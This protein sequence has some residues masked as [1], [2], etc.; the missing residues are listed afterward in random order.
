MSTSIRKYINLIEGYAWESNEYPKFLFEES[1]RY[2]V[3]SLCV[4]LNLRPIPMNSKLYEILFT[5][6]NRRIAFD[7]EWESK[8]MHEPWVA[9]SK[10]T[11]VHKQHSD[12]LQ[13]YKGPRKV[14]SSDNNLNELQNTD[15]QRT[16]DIIGKISTDPKLQQDLEPETDR[17]Y[18][19]IDF[20]NVARHTFP[21]FKDDNGQYRTAG[22]PGFGGSLWPTGYIK[23]LGLKDTP[24]S[25]LALLKRDIQE[26]IAKKLL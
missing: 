5:V 7:A 23:Q 15:L 19:G 22:S 8:N 6:Y 21:L 1:F 4:S 2:Q 17:Y 20:P 16:R 24:Q 12:Q 18:L 25:A 11:Y 9:N 26:S 10:H 3:S 13:F 14:E